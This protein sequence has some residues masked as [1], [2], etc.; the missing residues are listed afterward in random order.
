MYKC[1]VIFDPLWSNS[2]VQLSKLKNHSLGFKYALS[3]V[4]FFKID[5]QA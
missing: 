1:N 2:V 3:F 4:N 5:L